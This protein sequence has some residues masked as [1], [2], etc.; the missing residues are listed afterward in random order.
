MAEGFRS[1]PDRNIVGH[2]TD[3]FDTDKEFEKKVCR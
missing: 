2:Q 1:D 3:K